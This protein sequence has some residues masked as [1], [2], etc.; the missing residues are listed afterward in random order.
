MYKVLI[1]G[2]NGLLGQ[3]LLDAYENRKDITVLATGIGSNRN[4]NDTHLYQTLDITNK[5]K[6]QATLFN[7]QPNVVINTA[8]MTHVDQCEYEK[9]RCKQL[10][11]LAVSYLAESCKKI[12]SFL[13]QLSTDFIFDGKKGP[14]KEEDVPN[15]L[16]YYAQTKLDAEKLLSNTDLRHAIV[17]TILVYGVNKDMSRTN[18]I[19]WVKDNLERHQN[20]QV[21][22]DQWR[23]PTLAEDLAKGCILIADKQQEGIFNIGGKDMLTPYDM[24]ISTAHSFKLNK[25]LIKQVDGNIFKQ[26]AIRPHKTGLIIEKAKK[27]LGYEPVSFQEGINIVKKQLLQNS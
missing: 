20:I 9:E 6:V 14:Y 19:L 10:N 15:P 22:N 24:A 26:K 23:T 16:S 2:A 1:T 8:A 25:K 4:K 7:Y 3:K 12:N 13:I 18:I 11:V 21:V 27:I 5:E 17:R